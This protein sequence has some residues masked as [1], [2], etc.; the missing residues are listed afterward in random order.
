MMVPAVLGSL[1]VRLQV[2]PAMIAVSMMHQESRGNG[3]RATLHFIVLIQR[4]IDRERKAALDPRHGHD[5][6]VTEAHQRVAS[7][8]SLLIPCSSPSPYPRYTGRRIC[9]G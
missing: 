9:S 7:R 1:D 6:S 5:N 4:E 2:L 3:G 8:S